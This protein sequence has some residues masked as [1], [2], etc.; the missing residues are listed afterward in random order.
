METQFRGIVA[1]A[2]RFIISRFIEDFALESGSGP[3]VQQVSLC[4]LGLYFD[5][6]YVYESHQA[7]FE[8]KINLDFLFAY[9]TAYIRR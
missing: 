9:C 3:T 4:F 8:V 6:I 5:I 2:D 7:F 1:V